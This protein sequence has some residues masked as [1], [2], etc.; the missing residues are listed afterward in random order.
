MQYF[1]KLF[2]TV[3]LSFFFL[4][5]SFADEKTAFINIEYIIQNSNIGQKVLNGINDLNKKNI[6]KLEKKNKDLKELEA[7]IKNKKN[8]ISDKEFNSEVKAFQKKVQDLTK[9]KDIIVKEFNK[10]RKEELE[11]ILSLFNPIISNYMNE[12]SVNI[13]I[14]SK[15]IF[16]GSTDSNLTEDILK[17]INDEIK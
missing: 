2:I 5:T 15:N 6:D 11:K 7:S 17:R 13:L 16:M 9:E 10:Y 12:N 14:D 1:Y 8:I 3:F 4:V